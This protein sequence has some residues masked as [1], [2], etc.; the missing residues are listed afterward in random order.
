MQ[1][2]FCLFSSAQNI[3][4]FPTFAQVGIVNIYFELFLNLL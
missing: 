3:F 1:D 4:V 2:D